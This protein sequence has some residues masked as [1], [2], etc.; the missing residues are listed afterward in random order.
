MSGQIDVGWAAAPFGVEAVEQGKIRII[1][2]ASDVVAFR[3]QTSRVLAAN[4][5]ALER[6]KDVFVRYMRGYREGLDWLYTDPRALAAYAEWAGTS[7]RVARRLRDEF[8]P[9]TDVDPSNIAGLQ[10]LMAQAVTFKFMP[11]A[12]SDSQLNELIQRY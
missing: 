4:A 11:A 9:K 10:E 1:A 8:L 6:R 7:E 2:R 5:A 12:L 3:T